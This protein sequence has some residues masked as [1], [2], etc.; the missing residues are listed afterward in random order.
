[1]LSATFL[2][3]SM[4]IWYLLRLEMRENI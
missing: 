2:S 4:V 1:V 3:T